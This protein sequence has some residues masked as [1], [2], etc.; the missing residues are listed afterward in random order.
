MIIAYAT[1]PACY[2]SAAAYYAT[3]HDDGKVS[4][5]VYLDG[6]Y[7]GV[8]WYST[9]ASGMGVF[10]HAN[11]RWCL[12]G[13]SGG[14]YTVDQFVQLGVPRATATRLIAKLNHG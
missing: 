5:K 4:T 12:L 10:R 7:A 9:H 1:P 8:Q 3:Q 11:G 14:A 13:S 6:S 2:A